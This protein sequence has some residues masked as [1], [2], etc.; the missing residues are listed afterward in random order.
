MSV[1]EM[2]RNREKKG[3]GHDAACYVKGCPNVPFLM[4]G[5]YCEEHKHLD[6]RLTV[7]TKT[8][9]EGNYD[10]GI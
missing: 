6:P 1:S 7:S 2:R 9:K 8:P 5:G 10:E 3:D 4:Y